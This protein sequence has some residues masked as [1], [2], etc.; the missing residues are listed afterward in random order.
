MAMG[1]SR[2]TRLLT[3]DHNLRYLLLWIALFC[4]FRCDTGRKEGLQHF[5]VHPAQHRGP[6]KHANNIYSIARSSFS[7]SC[8]FNNF[9]C[10]SQARKSV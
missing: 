4:S 9:E 5:P 7:Q 3:F 6:V 8:A 2:L 10:R 1:G